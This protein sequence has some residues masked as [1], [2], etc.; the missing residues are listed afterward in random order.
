MITQTA[1]EPTVPAVPAPEETTE[2]PGRKELAWPWRPPPVPAQRPGL[3]LRALPEHSARGDSG[4]RRRLA[5]GAGGGSRAGRAS[6]AAAARQPRAQP[7]GAGADAAGHGGPAA[8]DGD[9]RV[10]GAGGR[11]TDAPAENEVSAAAQAAWL[12]LICTRV[13]TVR[14]SRGTLCLCTMV[15]SSGGPQIYTSPEDIVVKLHIN[16]AVHCWDT[17]VYLD[18]CQ[19]CT[20]GC[21]WSLDIVTHAPLSTNLQMPVLSPQAHTLMYIHI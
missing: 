20:R 13:G 12:C 21:P 10:G 4:L 5:G 8:A 1:A 3:R 19:S 15:F 18:S 7:A 17:A 11:C 2:A 9:A 16:F 14:P 6:Q